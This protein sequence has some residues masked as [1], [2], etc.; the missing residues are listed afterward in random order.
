MAHK[1][2]FETLKQ[3]ADQLIADRA[4][5]ENTW[6]EIADNLMGRKD[7]TVVRTPGEQRNQEIYDDTAKVSSSLLS[8]AIHTLM[9]SP[10][11]KWFEYSFANPE[12]REISVAVEWLK[13]A[14]AR[15]YSAL[16]SPKANFH[17]QLSE[18]YSDL[19]DFGT[20]GLF[21][22]D[23]AGVGVQFSTR[24]LQELYLAEDP[25]GNIDIVVRRYQ[26]TARQAVS[27]WGDDAKAATKALAGGS[28]ENRH[29]YIQIIMPSDDVTLGNI[30]SSGMPW[31]SFILSMAD[32]AIMSE[33]GF[34]EMPIATPRWEKNP[35]EV[36]GRGPGWNALSNGK[37][38]NAMKRSSLIY[39]Q[40][41]A[42]PTYLVDSEGVLPG[43]LR[44]R[45]NGIVP[46]NSVMSGGLN[47]P[48]Q[49]L[50]LGGDFN[51]TR[52]LI[53]DARLAVQDSF[54]HQLVELLRDPRMTATQVLELVAQ[55]QRHL[56]PIL[57]RL[58]TELL[59]PV[60]DR[61]FAIEERAGRLPPVP[62][63]IA[64]IVGGQQIKVDYVNPVARAQQ[65]GEARAIIDFSGFASQIIQVDPESAHVVDFQDGLRKLGTAMSVPPTMLHDKRETALRIEAQAELAAEQAAQDQAVT[66]TDQ[67]AKLAKA[68]P[69]QPQGAA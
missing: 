33:G 9:T 47:P 17:A 40:K 6:Q 13:S 11:A 21:V 7:F 12:L 28:M 34:H 49:P 10:V 8:G 63:E 14:E 68:I 29:D 48:I 36:F 54:L 53:Q 42:E 64:E 1:S 57:G 69:D 18:T 37:M 24:P 31:S 16:R 15:I 32:N 26:L 19:I 43:D 35:G 65:T 67:I 27:L 30:D 66:A 39:G 4:T 50:A 51:I 20:G 59:D 3:I 38:V 60:L 62:P 46:I 41:A 25:S 23:V 52:E 45:P 44:L 61:V 2:T 58:T 56:A 5:T 22:D 55:N